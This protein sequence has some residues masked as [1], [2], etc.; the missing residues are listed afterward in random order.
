MAIVDPVLHLPLRALIGTLLFSYVLSDSEWNTVLR[1]HVSKGALL[2]IPL[3]VV[4]YPGIAQ[5]P[6]FKQFIES[7]ASINLASLS[8]N[9]SF[10]LGINAYNAFAARTLIDFACKFEDNENKTGACLGP[11]YGLPDIT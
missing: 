6:S 4:Y 5:D 9:E 10:A 7:L 3:H 11:A 8:R 1:R 2:G